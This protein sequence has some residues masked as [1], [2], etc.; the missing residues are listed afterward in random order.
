MIPQKNRKATPSVAVSL[1]ERL[2]ADGDPQRHMEEIF[3][4]NVLFAAYI[5]T[6]CRRPTP[7][8]ADSFITNLPS[9]RIRWR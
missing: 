4:Q 5:G 8:H 1:I 7:S 9:Y 2:P 6:W 3:A